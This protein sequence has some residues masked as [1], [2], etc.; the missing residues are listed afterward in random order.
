MPSALRELGLLRRA[1]GEEEEA[2]RLEQQAERV[3]AFKRD[4][5]QAAASG[6]TRWSS[7]KGV[8]PAGREQRQGRQGQQG[9]RRGGRSN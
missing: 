7:S 1:Q 2:Q 4:Q 9:R 6:K 5:V 8:R 3:N